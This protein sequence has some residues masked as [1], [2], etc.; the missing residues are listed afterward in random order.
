[1]YVGHCI[2]T[3]DLRQYK[4]YMVVHRRLSCGLYAVSPCLMLSGDSGKIQEVLE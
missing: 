4:L 1:M 2:P 3:F